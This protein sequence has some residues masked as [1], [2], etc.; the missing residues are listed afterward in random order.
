MDDLTTALLLRSL[1]APARRPTAPAGRS[2][3]PPDPLPPAPERQEERAMP[4]ITFVGM[5]PNGSNACG[6]YAVVAA[7]HAF[8]PDLNPAGYELTVQTP[9]IGNC[10]YRLAVA[11]PGPTV[12]PPQPGPSALANQVYGLTGVLPAGD[13]FTPVNSAPATAA[14]PPGAALARVQNRGLNTPFAMT[15]AL[16]QLD[17]KLRATVNLTGNCRAFLDGLMGDVVAAEIDLVD[18]LE[19]ASILT[20]PQVYTSAKALQANPQVEGAVQIA[21]VGNAKAPVMAM[22]WL[23]R[24]GDDLWYDPGNGT[25]DNDWD[26]PDDIDPKLPGSSGDFGEATL[27]PSYVWLGLW[28]DAIRRKG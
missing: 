11:E 16:L 6:A 9:H 3:A 18:M 21:L 25:V 12:N 2:Q 26:V 7:A 4:N 17:G 20:G 27:G 24:G 14:Q 28:I 1:A 8:Q 22:H 10:S 13:G 19:R 23:V 5:Q 15:S